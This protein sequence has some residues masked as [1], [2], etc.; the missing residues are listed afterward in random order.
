MQ[1]HSLYCVNRRLEIQHFTKTGAIEG[2]DYGLLQACVRDGNDSWEL[3]KC[4]GML[5]I[6]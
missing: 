1:K 6:D 5:E 3:Q 4:D 2:S